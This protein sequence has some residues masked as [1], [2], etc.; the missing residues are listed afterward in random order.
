[1]ATFAPINIMVAL[2]TNGA[3]GKLSLDKV[4]LAT[5]ND[6]RNDRFGR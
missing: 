2:T 5:Q 1:M 4:A 3:G 6:E